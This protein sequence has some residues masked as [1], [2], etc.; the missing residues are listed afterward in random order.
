MARLQQIFV[1]HKNKPIYISIEVW[2]E[3][4]ELEP[5]D[6]LTLIWDDS[7]SPDIAQVNVVNDD[8]LVFWPQGQIDD[9]QF[10]I[11]GQPARDR[12]WKFKHR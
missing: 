9:M 11:N 1:N 10:L 2:P 4:F 6:T 5:G 12:S 7:D 8:E 3:C